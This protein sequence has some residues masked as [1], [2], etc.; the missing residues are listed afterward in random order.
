MSSHYSNN[1]KFEFD[2]LIVGAGLVG[3]SLVCALEPLIKQCQ[4]RCALVEPLDLNESLDQSREKPPSFDARASALSYGTQQTYQKLG[5]W[6]SLDA[7]AQPISQVHVSDKGHFGVARLSA[8]QEQVPALGYVIHNYHL[9]DVLMARLQHFRQEQLIEV[10]SPEHVTSLKPVA[11]GMDVELSSMT[12]S[13]SL[14]ILANGGRSGLMDQLGITRETT[15]YEQH[16]LIANLKLDRSH[17][18]IAYER[19]A[20]KGPI[21]LLPLKG[22]QS[23]L[24]WIVPQETVDSILHLEDKAFLKTVQA[25][26]GYRAGCFREVSKR[27]SYPLSMSI[28][29]EQVRPGLVV[30]GNAAHALHPVAGQ[31]Y[32]LAIRDVMALA[33]NIAGS[34]QQGISPGDLTRLLAYQAIQSSDQQLT[35]AFCHHLVQLFSRQ[36]QLSILARNLGLLGL[37]T[38]APVKSRF[39]QKAMG[40]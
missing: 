7:L 20:G 24:V 11:G 10:F 37:D 26:F 33:D 32:N 28:A 29:E 31:G 9:G 38:L 8:E 35:S 5:L 34:L 13:A 12:T 14:V 19:F 23:A 17:G 1:N 40:R 36:D 21:A 18:G 2:L 3:A 27:H 39:A 16:A 30:L 25:Q 6:Q 22:D 15:Q 4:L